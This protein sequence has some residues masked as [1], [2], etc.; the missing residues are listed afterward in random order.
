MS[1]M[2]ELN[3]QIN[4]IHE[5]QRHIRENCKHTGERRDYAEPFYHPHTNRMVIWSDCLECRVMQLKD[6]GECV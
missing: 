4:E 2:D 1:R 6:V 5:E 3:K